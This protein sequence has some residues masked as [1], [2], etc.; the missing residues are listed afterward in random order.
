MNDKINDILN[1]VLD[2]DIRG[3]SLESEGFQNIVATFNID[4]NY[5]V[6][7]LS[8][9]K[10]EWIEA[11]I[12]WLNYL[13]DNGIRLAA[14]V[15]FNG[16][17][18]IIEV[19]MNQE[20]YLLTFFQHTCGQPVNVLDS[21][22]W[23][24][25]FF[26]RWG[27]TI[28]SLHY[29]SAS[30]LDRPK[31]SANFHSEENWLNECKEYLENQLNKFPKTAN[32]FGLIHNDLHQGNFHIT[33]GEI[34]LFDFDDCGYQFL[35]QDLAVSVYHSLWTGTSFHPEWEDF[36]NY[37][38]THFLE[39]YLSERRLT[40]D[41]YEQLLILLQMR[42]LFLY[43]LFKEKWHPESMQ[44]WQLEKLQELERHLREKRIPYERELKKVKHYFI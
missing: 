34:V 39:G 23:N 22:E 13:Q 41:M 20:S 6:A 21:T 7:R 2:K 1:R 12:K 26:Y 31:G 25:E 10:K 18:K 27:R 19:A 32:N 9:K 37:F 43:N 11:E 15:Q 5:Y 42:E 3:L 38:L 33:Q 44:D 30:S 28:G 17:D 24:G 4:G 8:N 35:A 29:I 14:P 40:E 36:P 16:L